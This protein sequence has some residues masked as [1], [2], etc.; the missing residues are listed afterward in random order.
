MPSFVPR[1]AKAALFAILPLGVLLWTS[2]PSIAPFTLHLAVIILLTTIG[3][4]FVT[5]EKVQLLKVTLQVLTIVLL[6]GATGWF[7]SPFFFLLYLV[8]LYL[9]FVYTPLVAF[10]FLAALLVIFASSVGET[11]VAYDFM[12]LLSLLLV[13]P[14]VIYLRKKYLALKQ[15]NKDILI[16]ETGETKSASS[17]EHVLQNKVNE[18]GT[19]L[20]QPVTYLKQGLAL[21]GDT[22]LTKEEA[23]DTLTRMRK[24]AEE[25]FSLIKEF[26]RGTTKNVLLK[27]NAAAKTVKQPGSS[28]RKAL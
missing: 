5:A 17:L 20:R 18:L 23:D 26:E 2:I 11:D 8:P 21:M 7:F 4:S 10:S 3:I 27:K 6:V 19:L 13:V 12:T 28:V 25:L 1:A 15:S 24:A 16:L 9:G 22:R 14:L